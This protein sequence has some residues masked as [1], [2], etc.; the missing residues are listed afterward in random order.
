MVGQ[1]PR[2][3]HGRTKTSAPDAVRL[4][5]T[6]IHHQPNASRTGQARCRARGAADLPARH[7]KK[8]KLRNDAFTR[9]LHAN[10]PLSARLDASRPAPPPRHSNRSERPAIQPRQ[11]HPGSAPLRNQTRPSLSNRQ[12]RTTQT[13]LP[14]AARRSRSLC[15]RRGCPSVAPGAAP[16]QWRRLLETPELPSTYVM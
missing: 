14:S 3:N 4:A 15:G 13:A 5:R 9:P 16:A 2:A 1:R 6:G 10:A 7:A 8:G 11:A 12:T